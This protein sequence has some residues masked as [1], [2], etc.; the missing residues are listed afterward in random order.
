MTASAS[1]VGVV[2]ISDTNTYETWQRYCGFLDLT[3]PEFMQ[4][5]ERLLPEQVQLAYNSVLGR[6]IIGDTMPGTVEEF[7]KLVPFTTYEDYAPFLNEKREDILPEKPVCWAYTSGRSGASKYV[8]YTKRALDRITEDSVGTLILACARKKGDVRLRPGLKVVYNLPPR[9]YFSGF[10]ATVLA[11][12][13]GLRF[14]PSVEDAEGMQFEDRIKQSFKLAMSHGVDIVG[15]QTSVLVRIA[16][17]FASQSGKISIG[18]LMSQPKVAARGLRGKLLSKL[19]RRPMLPRDLWSVK[20]IICYGMDTAAY[21]PKL[22]ECWGKEPYEFYGST[23]AGAAAVQ[24]WNRKGLYFSPFP[25]FPEF[26]S[27]SE[28]VKMT[29]DKGYRPRS[30]LLSEVKPGERYEVFITSF[31]GMPFLRYRMEDIFEVVS[32]ED[33]ETGIKLPEFVFAG[34]VR[35]L[36]DLA[37]F[38]QLG[39]KDIWMAVT[40]SGLKLEDWTA[41][42]EVVASEPVLHVYLEPKDHTTPHE[43]EEALHRALVEV[44]WNYRDLSAMLKARSIHATLLSQGTFKRYYEEKKAEGAPLVQ[45]KPPRMNAPQTTLDTL[46]RHSTAGHATG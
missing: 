45:L 42:K 24:T 32:L 10:M 31:Y 12:R 30:C 29:N 46:L 44:N 11:D 3:V 27:E 40:K 39:E 37:G 26:V 4:I 38:A 41:R 7:R 23:E 1:R 5:Q 6:K 25:C 22:L 34:R 19:A 8:P 14:L 16:E 20:A 17:A 36:I 9:P 2:D 18:K 33:K 35:D 28:A 21:K 43:V 13:L 15:S